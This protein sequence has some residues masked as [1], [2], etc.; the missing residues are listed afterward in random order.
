MANVTGMLAYIIAGREIRCSTVHGKCL[1]QYYCSNVNRGGSFFKST[2]DIS[3]ETKLSERFIRKV[4]ATWKQNGFVTWVRGSNLTGDA[5][6]YTLNLEKLQA[7]AAQSEDPR[8]KA[9]ILSNLKTAERMRRYRAKQQSRP[10][11]V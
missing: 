8:D 3:S 9:R 4:N 2:V 7:A 11:C 10:Q 1:L 6:R 5:N